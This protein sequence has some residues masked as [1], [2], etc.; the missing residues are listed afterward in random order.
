MGSTFT[1]ITP[2]IIVGKEGGLPA[3]FGA[4]IVAGV[5]TWVVAPY[6]SDLYE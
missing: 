4:T 2:A 1:G 5:L 3:V 6:F